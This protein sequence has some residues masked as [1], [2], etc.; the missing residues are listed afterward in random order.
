MIDTL[1]ED[2]QITCFVT[3]WAIWYARRKIIFQDEYQSPLSTQL[4]VE[5]YLRDLSIAGPCR[6]V[7]STPARP[8][9]PRCISPKPGYMKLNADAAMAKTGPGGALA[10]VCRTE[11]GTFLGAST[12]TVEGIT[13]PAVLEAIACWEALALAQ[14]LQIQRITAASDWLSVINAM[15]TLYSGSFSVVLDEVKADASRLA[16]VSFRHKNRASNSEAHRLARFAV[17][18]CAGRQ[19]WFTQPPDGLC[20]PVQVLVQ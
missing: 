6:G 14:D 4:F 18:G 8:A 9:H 17:S 15:S 3:L 1:S 10:A 7:G 5:S 16:E 11:T 12:L 19:V 2:D 13:D 20:I